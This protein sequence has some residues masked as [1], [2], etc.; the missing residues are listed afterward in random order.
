[1]G[2]SQNRWKSQ[3]ESEAETLATEKDKGLRE[4]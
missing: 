3:I 4:N 1:M 2:Y